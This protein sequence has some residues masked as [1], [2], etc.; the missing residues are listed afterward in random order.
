MARIAFLGL[1]RMGTA[2]ATRLLDAGHELTVWNRSREKTQPFRDRPN[3]TVAVSPAEAASGVD[4]SI[5]MLA[6]KQ[7][8]REVLLGD[9]GVVHADGPPLL[10]IDMSTVGPEAVRELAAAL[11]PRIEMID[12]PVAGS[13]PQATAGELKI[14]VG[15]TQPA[16]DRARPILEVLGKPQ[17]IGDVTAGAAL[18]LV[19]NAQLAAVAVTV[20]EA[21]A[22]ARALDIDPQIAVD[23]LADTYVGGAIRAKRPLI[24]SR[25]MATNFALHLAAKDLRLVT[26]AAHK[27]GITLSSADA[28]RA[29]FEAAANAG[30]AD[31]DYGAIIPFIRDSL[32]S[33]S[34]P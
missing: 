27:A 24:D 3:A 16:F 15:A 14:F 25:Q 29:A 19:V 12:A 22:L 4:V 11:A 2:M 32:A 10:H 13:V 8:L 28:N 1:G 6:D 20:G 5:T 17:H 21:L 33:R 31:A 7:A 26:E 9:N 18:K 23:T 34:S 30:L